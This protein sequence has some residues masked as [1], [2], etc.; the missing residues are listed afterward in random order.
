MLCQVVNAR[1]PAETLERLR[2]VEPWA[3]DGATVAEMTAG[4]ALL[5]VLED[6]QPVGA[7]AVEIDGDTATITAAMFSGEFSVDEFAYIE[8]MLRTEGVRR[9]VAYTKRPGV[10]RRLMSARGF[11]LEEAR[12]TKDL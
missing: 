12:M 5:D 6:G 3:V 7:V 9:L 8:R 10:V 2:A 4:C 11:R 1:N